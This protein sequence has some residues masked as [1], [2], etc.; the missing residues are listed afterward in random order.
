MPSVA[1]AII[2]AAGRGS[3]MGSLTEVR[4]KCLIELGGRTLLSWQIAACRA[5]GIETI[6]VVRGYRADCLRADGNDCQAFEA[7][8]NRRW[9]VTNMVASL[10]CAAAYLKAGPCI[11]SYADIAYHPTHLAALSH[12]DGEIAIVSDR[13]WWELWRERFDDPLQDAESFAA[14]ADVLSDIGRRAD[15]VDQIQGQYV[16]L[17]KFTSRGWAEVEGLLEQLAPTARDALDMTSLL[18]AL[19]ERGTTIKV[20][21]VDG[22]WVEVDRPE[23]WRLYLQRLA[24]VDAGRQPWRH[25]WRW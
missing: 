22:C 2:L 17:S 19:L 10:A 25:D 5:I 1:T 3:R 16:G 9:A 23:D 20:A 18:R 14:E 13:Q 21:P 15:S 24:D 8:D 6:V 12:A 11:V 4:P 7:I